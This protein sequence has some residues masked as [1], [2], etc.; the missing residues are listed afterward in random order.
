MTTNDKSLL[1]LSLVAYHAAREKI[2]NTFAEKNIL[3][4]C[5]EKVCTIFDEIC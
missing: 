3:P 4:V 1:S 5:M 2:A